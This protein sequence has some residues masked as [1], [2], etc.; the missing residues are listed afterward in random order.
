MNVKETFRHNLMQR[1]E[2]E[3]VNVQQICDKLQIS[4]SSFY[5]KMRE[6]TWKHIDIERLAELFQCQTSDF[7]R[8]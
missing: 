3:H 8:L 1:M 4:R 6:G 5:R 7:V 2:T